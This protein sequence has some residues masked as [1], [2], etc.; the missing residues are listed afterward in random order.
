MITFAEFQASKTACD[1]IGKVLRDARWEDDP[2]PAKGLIY[3]GLLYIE[4]VQAWWPERARE[5]GKY[6][7]LIGRTDWISDDLESLE[8]KLYEFA[9]DEGYLL[10]PAEECARYGHARDTGR[11]VCSRCGDAL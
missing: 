3:L 8:R 2:M 4:E 10:T 5:L 6:H 11:G 9:D 7:L 1:D